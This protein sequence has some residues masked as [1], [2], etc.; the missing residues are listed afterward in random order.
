MEPTGRGTLLTLLAL[1]EGPKHGYEVSTWIA[2]RSRGFFTLSFGAL[3]PILHRLEQAGLIS[4][5]WSTGAES[6]PKK[7][8]ALTPAGQ[9]ALAAERERYEQGAQAMALLLAGSRT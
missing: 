3:Y 5:A 8:Y 4:G 7:V 1:Q 6:R 2:E 9:A